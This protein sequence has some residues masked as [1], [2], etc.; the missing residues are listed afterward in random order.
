MTYKDF[1]TGFRCQDDTAEINRRIYIRRPDKLETVEDVAW[2]DSETA[3]Y[4]QRLETTI[5]A[6]KGYRQALAA[7]YGELETMSYTRLLKL[8][9]RPHWRGNIEYTVTITR[10]LADGTA[11]PELREVF[12]GN[13]RH[14][15]KSRFQ[16]LQKQY[17]GIPTEQDTEKRTWER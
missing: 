3:Q 5:E 16:T 14:K 1:F 6:L 10:T 2:Y 4:I 8:E 9:R 12:P 7:R 17:P 15:A 13:E 11:I